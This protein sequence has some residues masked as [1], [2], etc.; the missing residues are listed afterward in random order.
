QGHDRFARLTLTHYAE[1]TIG[2]GEWSCPVNHGTRGERNNPTRTDGSSVTEHPQESTL[3]DTLEQVA[4]DEV[5]NRLSDSLLKHH[6]SNV[7]QK[8]LKSTTDVVEGL[9]DSHRRVPKGITHFASELLSLRKLSNTLDLSLVLIKRLD[10]LGNTG[11]LLF[12]YLSE[13]D[14]VTEPFKLIDGNSDRSGKKFLIAG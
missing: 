1:V 11:N 5:R 2:H 7:E 6:A 9:G 13:L 3:L 12:D 4:C 8:V 14:L 10:G